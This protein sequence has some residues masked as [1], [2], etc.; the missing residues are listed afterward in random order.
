MSTDSVEAN[1]AFAQTYAFPFPLLSDTT[2]EICMAYGA[3]SSPNAAQAERITYV[4]GPDGKIIRVFEHVVAESHVDELLTFLSTSTRSIP[5]DTLSTTA[6]ISHMCSCNPTTD[7]GRTALDQQQEVNHVHVSESM[8]TEP[9]GVISQPSVAAVQA[10]EFTPTGQAAA[11]SPPMASTAQAPPILESTPSILPAQVHSAQDGMTPSM[12]YALGALSYDFGT[13][14]RRDSIMQH[15]GAG[16]NPHDPQ[17]LL[18]YLENNPW[19][20]AAILWTL[21]SDATP[22]YVIQPQGP[23]ASDAYRRLREFLKEQLT[24]GVERVSIAGLIVGQ[25]RL[26]SGLVV[27]VISPALRCMYSWTTAA[28]AQAVCG[29]PPS[30]TATSDEYEAY[31]QRSEAVGNFLERVYHELRNLGLSPQERAINYAATNALNVER[32]FESA[33]REEMELDAIEVERSPICRPDSDCWDVKL[34]FFDPRHQFERARRVYRF[35]VDVSDVC[36]VTV[37]M[38]R[39]WSVR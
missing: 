22:I 29:D 24:E 32:V 25:A 28:L 12:V 1:A 39:S 19:D 13:E 16:A 21:N 4:I 11:L 6:L 38:V 17:Q 5:P 31:G 10:A 14:A 7:T 26:F 2:R 35:T 20:A 34:T 36:P 8:P 30:D 37:G 33:L 9:E 23:F 3:C 27:P 18:A 15:M